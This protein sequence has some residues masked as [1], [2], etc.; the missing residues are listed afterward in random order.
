V[1]RPPGSSCCT[2]PSPCKAQGHPAAGPLAAAA[3]CPVWVGPPGRSRVQQVSWH[4]RAIQYP[5]PPP[6]GDDSRTGSPVC[7]A[8]LE[9]DFV[10]ANPD[11]VKEL[12]IMVSTKVGSGV[13]GRWWASCPR[14]RQARTTNRCIVSRVGSTV[15]SWAQGA[16]ARQASRAASERTV[17]HRCQSEGTW[18]QDFQRILRALPLPPR[19]RSKRRSRHSARLASSTFRSHTCH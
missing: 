17:E 4:A 2:F 1:R 5:P 19:C 18:D 13:T 9:E 10:R 15:G 11:W 3:V 14:A 16:P 6:L 12:E 8:Q 7:C